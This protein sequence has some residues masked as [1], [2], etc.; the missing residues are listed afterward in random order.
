MFYIL[1]VKEEFLTKYFPHFIIFF[2][3]NLERKDALFYIFV[4][5]YLLFLNYIKNPRKRNDHT[6]LYIYQK[7]P[8]L[9]QPKKKPPHTP[10]SIL[11]SR[12]ELSR[13]FSP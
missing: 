11:K 2:G 9:I 4:I 1:S 13:N 10:F 12:V 3:D 5:K 8:F 7:Q 6:L